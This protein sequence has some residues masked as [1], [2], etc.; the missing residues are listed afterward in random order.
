MTYIF[1]AHD[2]L[3][4]EYVSDRIAV[5]YLGKIVE[6]GDSDSVFRQPLHPYTA[7]LLS[8][9]PIPNPRYKPNR[10]ILQGDVPS[11]VNVPEG[12]SFHP[13]C[14]F[15]KEGLCNRAIPALEEIES[16]HFVACARTEEIELGGLDEFLGHI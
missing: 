8:A 11:P 16:G 10:T 1:I 5:M 6:L 14:Q 2:L 7:A 9:V 15:F 4:V 13:R 12:C 3:V